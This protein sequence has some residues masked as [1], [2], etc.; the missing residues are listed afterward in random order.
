MSEV[1]SAG[2]GADAA[3]NITASVGYPVHDLDQRGMW[4]V[5]MAETH[6]LPG[7]KESFSEWAEPDGRHGVLL[8]AVVLY[9]RSLA[10]I[11]WPK[12]TPE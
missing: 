1:R 5:R 2:K 7:A 4:F 3:S 6:E 10:R 8:D 12:Q 9:G 11:W